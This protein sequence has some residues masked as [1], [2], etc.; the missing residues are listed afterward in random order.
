MSEAREIVVRL[1]LNRAAEAIAEADLLTRAGHSSAGVSRLY[2]ACFYAA[3]A[4]LQ[5]RDLSSSKHS[6]VLSLFTREFVKT[7]II[8]ADVAQGYRELFSKRQ[9]ADYEPIVNWNVEDLEDWAAKAQ[10]F[11]RRVER[12]LFPPVDPDDEEAK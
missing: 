5:W 7:G 10:R 8:P 2:Y 12:M 3:T 4:A 11:V 6:G 1:W 9:R